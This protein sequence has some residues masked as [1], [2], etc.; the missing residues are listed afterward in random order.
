L[1]LGPLTVTPGPLGPFGTGGGGIGLF[2]FAAPGGV[3]GSGGG[4]DPKTSQLLHSTPYYRIVEMCRTY[5]YNLNLII[6]QTLAYTQ[7]ALLCV[8]AVAGLVGHWQ[9]KLSTVPHWCRYVA[10][11]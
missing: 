10:T 3:P 11:C 2:F 6:N 4:T 7:I 1:G 5:L 8:V 9:V